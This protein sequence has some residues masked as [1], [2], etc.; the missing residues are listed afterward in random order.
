MLIKEGKNIAQNKRFKKIKTQSNS[1]LFKT[2]ASDKKPYYFMKYW[3]MHPQKSQ[4]SYTKKY[5][6]KEDLNL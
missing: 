4:A 2:L 1:Q 5:M 6:G 3:R